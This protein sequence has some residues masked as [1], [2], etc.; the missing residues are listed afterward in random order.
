MKHITAKNVLQWFI[1][2]GMLVSVIANIA[3]PKIGDM[4]FHYYMA[5]IL[6]V[7]VYGLLGIALLSAFGLIFL[8]K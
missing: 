1:I 8:R 7:F 5:A 6:A 2:F 4:I 3:P